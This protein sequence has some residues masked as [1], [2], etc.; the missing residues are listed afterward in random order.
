MV[1]YKFLALLFCLVVLA[2]CS[3]AKKKTALPPPVAG[4]G[5]AVAPAGPAGTPAE[6]S[7]IKRNILFLARREWDYFGRQTVV[8]DGDEESIPHV[9]KWEDDEE[10][11]VYRV[12][13]YWRAVGKPHLNGKDCSEPWSAAFISWIMKE[14]GVPEEQFMPADAH[15]HY[16]TRIMA[17]AG[18]PGSAFVPHSIDSYS[19]SSAI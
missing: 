19:P 18:A 16:L 6:L 15:W 17:E 14:A 13:W 10:P 4:R 12:N 9:G 2:G 7:P 1:C 11:Y 8:F 3:G 5:P